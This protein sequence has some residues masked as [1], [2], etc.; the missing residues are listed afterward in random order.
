VQPYRA[1]S[2]DFRALLNER[3]RLALGTDW[4][5]APLNP[6]STLAAA[7][8]AQLT[9][10]EAVSAYTSGS[11]FAEFQEAEKGTIARGKL[12]DLVILSD[13]IFSLPPAGV[14]AVKVLTTIAGG[15]VVH[16]RRP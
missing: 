1:T 4:D 7:V 11:A 9:I 13:D 8:A 15:K 16:Q 2:Y 3:V 10:Q 5:A 14:S 6:M 12:A